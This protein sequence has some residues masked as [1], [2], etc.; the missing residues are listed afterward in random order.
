MAKTAKLRFK[1]NRDIPIY[2]LIFPAFILLVVF[3]YV[4]IYGIVMAFQDFS[5]F[6]GVAH[7]EWIG[8]KNFLYFIQD[9]NF[10]RVMKNTIIINVYQL[11][12]GF[13]VPV[14]FAI[15]LNELTLLKYK[16]LVQT[17]SYLPYFIS[18]VVAS[19]IFVAP[20][21]LIISRTSNIGTAY[22]SEPN[23]NTT[24]CSSDINSASLFGI[25]IYIININ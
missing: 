24:N 10:W 19:G 18:W 20:P 9:G 13:P 11:V 4:P 5:P 6:K 8:L 12:L 25:H 1:S 17:V 23:L 14:V 21:Y 15:L 22:S 7:S 3:H 16:K 2:L